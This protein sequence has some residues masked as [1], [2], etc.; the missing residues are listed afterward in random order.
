VDLSDAG[1]EELAARMSAAADRNIDLVIDPVCGE[2]TTAALQVLADGGRLVH[3]GASGGPIASFSSAV[4]R[5]KSL[6]VRGYTNNSISPEQRAEALARVFAL[7]GSGRCEVNHLVV[8][9]DDVADA[10]R[11]AAQGEER[12]VVVPA[13]APDSATVP[14][15]R[16]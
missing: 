9:L 12:V 15:Q 13:A 14:T 16:P 10:W 11:R 6:D 7:A 5:S 4:L 8:A 2:A 1:T 3:L